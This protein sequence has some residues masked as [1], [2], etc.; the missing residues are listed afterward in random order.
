MDH[1]EPVGLWLL[2][3]VS[4]ESGKILERNASD[5]N[6]EHKPQSKLSLWK[7]KKCKKKVFVSVDFGKRVRFAL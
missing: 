2:A 1:Q 5:G 6:L 4:L 3:I 7:R